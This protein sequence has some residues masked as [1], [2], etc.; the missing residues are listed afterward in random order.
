[1]TLEQWQQL[2]STL[3]ETGSKVYAAAARQATIEA[4]TA[5]ALAIVFGLCAIAFAVLSVR[6]L[7][8]DDGVSPLWFVALFFATAFFLPL[9]AKVFTYFSNPQWAIYET[10]ASLMQ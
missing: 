1:M 3:G 2:L 10:I 7:G 4:Y 6:D 8:K 5:L 9:A